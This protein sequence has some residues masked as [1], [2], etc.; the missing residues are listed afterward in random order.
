[1]RM[2]RCSA[3]SRWRAVQA[4]IDEESCYLSAKAVN[5]PSLYPLAISVRVHT[6]IDVAPQKLQ[7]QYNHRRSSMLWTPSFRASQ[8]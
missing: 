6:I 7:L 2:R 4:T 5:A 8:S 3:E 1:M